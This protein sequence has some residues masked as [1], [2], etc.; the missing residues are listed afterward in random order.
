MFS[1]YITAHKSKMNLHKN[2]KNRLISITLTIAATLLPGFCAIA[3]ELIMED[4]SRLLGEVIKSEDGI[5]NFKTSYAGD[6]KVKWPEI[7]KITS[8][9][10]VLILRENND[11]FNTRLIVNTG[12][13]ALITDESGNTITISSDETVYVNPDPWRMDKGWK[14]TGIVNVD[15]LYERGNTK[16]DDYYADWNTTVRNREDRFKLW[17]NYNREKNDDQLTDE[18]WR[19]NGRYDYFA[20]KKFFYGANL[21]VEH[22][23]PADI[24]RR[25][26]AG[27]Q[28][29]YQFYE[30]EAMNLDIS[31]GPQYVYEEFYVAKNDDYL[32]LGWHVDF[33]RFLIPDYVQLYHRQRGLMDS[34][35]TG[36]FIWDGWTGFRFPLY[37]GI[38]LSTELLLE[39][40]G[41]APQGVKK[42][43]TTYHLK[44]GY[45]W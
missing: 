44:L 31:G 26:V 16:K 33:D 19:L 15:L 34:R 2:F 12:N 39:Y 18:D 43:D 13:G 36:N 27:P 28:I 20:T 22:D 38:V 6:I 23:R 24:L 45:Q 30:S 8:E 11:T 21:S 37:A 3:D 25:T 35:D 17:G 10:P 5:V 9:K 29:G 1:T 7:I 32:G 4:G 42:T 40:D 41:G 14:W